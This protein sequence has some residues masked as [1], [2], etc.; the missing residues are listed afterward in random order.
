MVLVMT[1]DLQENGRER[2][3]TTLQ[4]N[5]KSHQRNESANKHPTNTCNRQTVHVS[6]SML[7]NVNSL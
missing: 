6:F 7:I 4:R 2:I 3:Q 1:R 5:R